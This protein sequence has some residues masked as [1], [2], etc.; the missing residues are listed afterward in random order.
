MK[1]KTPI[2]KGLRL[3]IGFD[4]DGLLEFGDGYTLAS[5]WASQAGTYDLSFGNN[6]MEARQYLNSSQITFVI[7]DKN[8]R[9]VTLAQSNDFRDIFKFNDTVIFLEG[10]QFYH[11]FDIKTNKVIKKKIKFPFDIGRGGTTKLNETTE[12][13]VIWTIDYHASTP[14]Y[15][16]DKFYILLKQ[17]YNSFNPFKKVTKALSG[18]RSNYER[19]EVNIMLNKSFEVEAIERYWYAPMNQY[20]MMQVFPENDKFKIEKVLIP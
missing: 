18:N 13:V 8:D 3:N 4:Q 12:D 20:G 6:Q 10:T 11:Y 14:K 15:D 19:F 9:F 16:M 1:F 5:F 2:P 7:Y 17:Y